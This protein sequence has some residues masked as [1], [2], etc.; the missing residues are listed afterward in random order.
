MELR[1][2]CDS[3]FDNKLDQ[4]QKKTLVFFWAPWCKAAETFTETLEDLAKTYDSNVQIFCMNV[5]ENANVPASLGVKTIPQVSLIERGTI[6][7]SLS[8]RQPKVKIRHH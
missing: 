6:T 8:G 1:A 3:D 4:S 5:D 2:I 7:S